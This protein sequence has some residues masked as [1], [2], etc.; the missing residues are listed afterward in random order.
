MGLETLI[1][2]RETA[3]CLC[4][5]LISFEAGSPISQAGLELHTPDSILSTFPVL[6]CG[7]E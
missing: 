2:G 5:Y 3:I 4:I 7:I 6:S 1:V